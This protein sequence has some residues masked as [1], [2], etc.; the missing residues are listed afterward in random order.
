MQPDTCYGIK[1][2]DE[3]IKYATLFPGEPIQLIDLLTFDEALPLQENSMFLGHMADSFKHSIP[4]RVD[5]TNQPL[6]VIHNLGYEPLVQVF[7]TTGEQVFPAIKHIN[8]NRFDILA[9]P[10]FTGYLIYR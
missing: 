10:V 7:K 4:R 8:L 1:I 6:E 9:T 5:F 2:A 3:P